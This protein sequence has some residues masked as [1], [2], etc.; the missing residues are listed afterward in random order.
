MQTF[1][2]SELV[3]NADGSIYHLNLKPED[4]ADTVLLVGDNERV[5]LI[6]SFFEKI[7]IKKENREFITHTGYY[8][9]KRITVIGT[10]IG[11]D[12]IDIV[13]NELDALV[14]IDLDKRE[15][16]LEKKSLNL[17]R[18]GTCGAIQAEAGLNCFIVADYGLGFDN[19]MSFYKYEPNPIEKKLT[20]KIIRHLKR[21]H[22]RLP[23]YL[24]QASNELSAL[25]YDG[26][27]HGIT[28]TSP[29]FYGPQSRLLR[30]K[31]NFPELIFWMGGFKYKGFKILNFEMETSALY[32]LANVLGHKALTVD[33]V[34]ANRVF[35]KFSADY[36][37]KMRTLVIR[38]LNTIAFT[39]WL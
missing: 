27:L 15:E 8:K 35:N 33:L 10:G 5:S 4:V 12:N 13:V 16:K 19:L 20:K 17:I 30:Y 31:L 25:F 6:S 37:E 39:E 1:P 7:D 11:T 18:I 14:N 26:Y 38:V 23:L 34:V 9:D 22:C 36:H 3:L 32:G 24:I 29:G 2:P 28:I 21:M